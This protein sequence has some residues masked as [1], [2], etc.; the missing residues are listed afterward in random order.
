MQGRS[1]MA[2]LTLALIFSAA[3]VIAG[4]GENLKSK[5]ET[6]SA[7]KAPAAKVAT[8]PGAPAAKAN[9][10]RAKS[11]K[12]KLDLNIAGLTSKGCDVEIKAAHAGCK[13]RDRTEHVT[14]NGKLV[15][16]LDDV[17]I[18]NADR[19]CTFAITI[20]EAGQ[21]EKTW[22]RGIRVN[23][24]PALAQ[25]LPCFLNSPSKLARAMSAETKTK[26]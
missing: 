26:R 20:R 18:L 10:P 22:R 12:I 19:D 4:E 15:V 5:T 17:E 24:T 1:W 9:G 2:A 3:A 7:L 13:F 23:A 11:H 21:A 14:S 25:T 16:E 6:P 8:A